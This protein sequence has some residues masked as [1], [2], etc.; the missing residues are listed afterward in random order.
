MTG[1]HRP[2][3]AQLIGPAV[4]LQREAVLQ[5]SR[6]ID[7]GIAQHR[8]VHG[9]EPSAAVHALQSLFQKASELALAE[10]EALRHSDVQA[11]AEMSPSK[12]PRNDEIGAREA[13]EILRLSPRQVTRIAPSLSGTGGSQGKP[14]RFSRADVESYR[15]AQQDR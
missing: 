4:L 14:W 10:V 9:I 8:R 1:H 11:M 13:A 15:A 5:T 7:L 12:K 2:P 6:L 3:A